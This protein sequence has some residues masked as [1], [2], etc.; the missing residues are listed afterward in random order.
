M[1]V[2]KILPT[3][4]PCT[5]HFYSLADL[6]KIFQITDDSSEFCKEYIL[7][8]AVDKGNINIVR[9]L[10]D[11]GA[12]PNYEPDFFPAFMTIAV[13][14]KRDEIIK[15][16]VEHRSKVDKK[17]IGYIFDPYKKNATELAVHVISHNK[18]DDKVLQMM[19]EGLLCDYLLPEA[20]HIL[21]LLIDHGLS[22]Q[23]YISSGM[24]ALQVCVDKGNNNL[25]STLFL[26]L[27]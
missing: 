4:Q 5:L 24:T 21:E 3:E 18:G 12:D 14:R 13:D 11:Q 19:F 7:L 27:V 26:Y 17:L 22:L 1:R 10:L 8:G 20:Q 2:S 9:K 6:K 15:L 25:V 23:N 16:L